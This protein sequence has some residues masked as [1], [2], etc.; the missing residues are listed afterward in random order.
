MKK[1]ILVFLTVMLALTAVMQ[2]TALAY[3]APVTDEVGYLT[4]EEINELNSYLDEVRSEYDMDVVVYIEEHAPTD[5]LLLHAS[6][7]YDDLGY[8]VGN[9]HDGI[10]MYISKYPRKYTFSTCGEGINIFNSRAIDRLTDV[11]MPYLRADDYYGAIQS[12]AD[13]TR[14]MLQMEADGQPY[15]EEDGY[16]SL[17]MWGLV[18]IVP[19]VVAAFATHIRGK[20]MN[21]AVYNDYAD[22]YMRGSVNLTTANDLFLYSTITR[23]P[24]VKNNTGTGGTHTSSSGRTHGGGG[25]GS[26]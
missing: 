19:L 7:I 25:G 24:R 15:G 13:E 8:G 26:Y 11:T 5:N 6:D 16:S 10:M 9:N 22:S 2:F 3:N 17:L 20:D 4:R 18:V 23:T 14:S 12:Y 1:R 21:T